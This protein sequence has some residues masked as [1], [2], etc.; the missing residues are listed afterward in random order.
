MAAGKLIL[1][2]YINYNNVR[3]FVS[4]L[5]ILTLLADVLKTVFS[6]SITVLVSLEV[7]ALL[8]K[9]KLQVSN[10]HI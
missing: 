7:L 9:M 8:T 4:Y 2:G 10:S 1:S 3:N 5:G 6:I